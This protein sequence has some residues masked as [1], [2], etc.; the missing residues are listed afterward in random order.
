MRFLR[1]PD[2]V[3][4]IAVT[5]AMTL[6]WSAASAAPATPP[7]PLAEQSGKAEKAEKAEKSRQTKDDRRRELNYEYAKLYKAVSALRFLDE[8]LLVKFE[9]DATEKLVKQIAD[10]GSRTRSELEDIAHQHPEVSLEDDGRTELARES[11]KR[12]TRDRLKAFAPL[13][14][15]SGADFERMLLLGQQAAL[16]QLRFRT[17]VM[18]DA[19]TSPARRKWLRKV[20]REGEQLYAQT[21][22]LL[23]RRYF[24]APAKTPRGA[25]GGDD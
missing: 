23:D 15:A 6:A 19:E 25:A 4:S 14:G 12:Q 2:L 10:F 9:S 11:S 20:Q 7:A 16:Y 24:R 5:L 22:E 1:L 18:A 3:A 21:L 8:L 17:D 13:T